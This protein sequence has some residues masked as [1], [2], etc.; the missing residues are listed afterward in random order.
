MNRQQRRAELR[1]KKKEPPASAQT[2]AAEAADGADLFAQALWHQHQRKF[3]DA[4]RLFKRLLALEPDHAEAWNNLGC[5]LLAQGKP[6]EAIGAFQRTLTL[7]PQLLDDFTSVL[8][9]MVSVNTT[10]GE[11][12]KRAAAAWP[13]RRPA[14]ELLAPAGIAALADDP[15]LRFVLESTR[16]R[17]VGFERLLTSLRL[18]LLRAAVAADG[19]IDDWVLEFSCAL[20][21]QCF[22]NEYVFAQTP[23]EAEHT[24]TIE[25]AL[26]QA[27]ASGAPVSPARLAALAMYVPLGSLPDAQSLLERKWPQALDG[28]LAQQLREPQEERRLQESIPRLTVIDDDVSLRVRRQYE[29]NPYPRWVRSGIPVREPVTVDEHLRLQFPSAQFHS[30][31]GSGEVDILVAGCGTGRHPIGV[32][33]TYRDARILAVDLSLTS[34]AYAKRKTPPEFAGRIDYAQ[35]DILRLPAIGRTF[36]LIDASGV[37]HHMADPLAVWRDLLALLRPGGFMHLGLYSELARRDVVAA[38]AF[39]AERGYGSTADDIRRCRQDLIDSLPGIAKFGDFFSTSECRD[40]LLH[41]QERR[42]TIPDIKSFI[43]EQ[44]LT[45]IGFNFSPQDLQRYRGLFGQ[46]GWSLQD[47][48][49]W[50]AIETENPDTFAGMYQF[51]VQKP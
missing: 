2:P 20:A 5:A 8:A 33:Q 43:A 42:L 40:L 35:A 15:L 32:A 23:E 39:I 45:F 37:L 21:Q 28:L 27:L 36:D 18:T 25:H 51:W 31:G 24:A 34:L 47:L 22:I 46:A 41:V 19:S 13:Q 29:E 30:L 6:A 4:E 9:L 10:L 14:E 50:H 26:A 38:R 49:R 1:Q 12:L 44:G 48:D 16:V 7:L 17:N 3:D 11:G